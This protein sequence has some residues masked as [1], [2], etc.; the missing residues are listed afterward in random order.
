MKIL[1]EVCV[2][3]LAEALEAEKRGA[4]RIELCDNLSFGGTTHSL[5]LLHI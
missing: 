5:S 3:N 1:K 2:E 4:D